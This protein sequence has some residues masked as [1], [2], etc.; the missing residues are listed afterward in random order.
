MFG[1]M[2]GKGYTVKSAQMEMSMIAEGY[3]A[4]KS[5]YQ[6]NQAKE[7]PAQT[8]IIDTV[9]EILY[10]NKNSKNAFKK[11]TEKLS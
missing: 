8:P 2:V 4:T 5:A 9:Y 10:L 1:N 3:Y 7:T 6:I 11:L